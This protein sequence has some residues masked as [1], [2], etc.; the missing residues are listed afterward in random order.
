M[1]NVRHWIRLPT[2]ADWRE[3]VAPKEHGS[4][5]LAFEP[6]ALGLM[7]A[8]SPG[9]AWLA[10]AM[11]AVFFTRRPLRLVW[12]E[13]G[14]ERAPVARG[15]LV[16][17]GAAGAFAMLGAVATAGAG[18]LVWLVPVAAGGAIFVWCDLRNTGRAALAEVAGATAFAFVPAALAALANWPPLAALA[19]AVIMAGR[20]VPTVLVVRAAL[21]LAKTGEFSRAPALLTAGGALV[22]GIWLSL[23]GLAPRV[24]ALALAVLALRTSVLLVYPR[25]VLR[26]RTIGVLEAALGVAFVVAVA[27]AWRA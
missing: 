5:S 25:P 19:L 9:G 11:T 6:I 24:A 10:A 26:A 13:A 23:A 15:A 14:E 2:P 21:R 16:L 4:W 7:A 17:C 18:W 8:P 20:A 1:E 12:R 3:V 27:R 22:A